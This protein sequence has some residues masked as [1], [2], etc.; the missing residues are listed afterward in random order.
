MK[1]NNNNKIKENIRENK[2]KIIFK[3]IKVFNN[4]KS[5]MKIKWKK[6]LKMNKINN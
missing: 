6:I 4:K 5:K 3:K 1:K 2:N